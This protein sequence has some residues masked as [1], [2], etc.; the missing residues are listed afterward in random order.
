MQPRPLGRLP[1]RLI[2]RHGYWSVMINII[3]DRGTD[4]QDFQI[5]NY[6]DFFIKIVSGIFVFLYRDAV[7]A[8][9][10]AEIEPSG[11]PALF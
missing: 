3:N 8:R 4:L 1:V 11:M 7:C 5:R 9:N 10:D 2:C 6:R